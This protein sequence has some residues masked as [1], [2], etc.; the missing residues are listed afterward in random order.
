MQIL[1]EG[2]GVYPRREVKRLR[3]LT[4]H[5]RG[6]LFWGKLRRFYLVHFRPSY[7]E[8][9][10]KRRVGQC[11]RTGAC[12]NVLF[13]CPLL[14][15]VKQLPLCGIYRKRPSNCTSFPIDERDLRDRNIVNPW[16]PCGFSFLEKS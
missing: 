4:W 5:E 7:V 12:C 3:S 11:H 16:E 13:P 15:W 8:E 9:S 2:V 10:L 1:Y 6:L 14:S